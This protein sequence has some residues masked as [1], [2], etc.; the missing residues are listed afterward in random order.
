MIYINPN[1]A[2]TRL[3]DILTRVE[4]FSD[5]FSL[6]S[7]EKEKSR[8]NYVRIFECFNAKKSF[9]YAYGKW[10]IPYRKE[11]KSS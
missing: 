7:T 1:V 5:R 6:R 11:G 10:K 2:D 9:R 4:S 3:L 8:R